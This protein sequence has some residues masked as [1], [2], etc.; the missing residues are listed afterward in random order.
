MKKSILSKIF[1]LFIMGLFFAN[2]LRAQQ[3]FPIVA[4]FTQLPP[5]PVYLADFSNPNQQNLSVQIQIRDQKLASRPIRLKLYIEGQ[6]FL[7]ESADLVQGEPAIQLNLG[8]I[9]DIPKAQLANYFKQ[10]NLKVTPDLY[11]KPFSEGRFRFGI[12]VIDFVTNRPLSGIQWGDPVFIVQNDPPVWVI[13]TDNS[14]QTPLNSQNINF[15]WA[16][17]HR[18]AS[19][20][21][22]EFTITELL[23]GENFSGNIQ[24]LFLSQ[25][26][27]K[28]YRTS[29]TT[30]N[31]NTTF[32]GL[33]PGRTYAYRVQAIAKRG[34]EDVGVFRNNGF[35]EIRHFKYGEGLKPPTN[36]KLAWN[37]DAKS[38]TF[39]WK[40]E[41]NHKSYEIEYREKGTTGEWKKLNVTPKNGLLNTEKI[42]SIQ[43][44]KTYDFKL[45][46][47]GDQNQRAA[48]PLLSI[49][50]ISEEEYLKKTDP[51]VQIEGKVEW[52]F[53][54][55]AAEYEDSRFNEP[56]ITKSVNAK[57]ERSSFQIA[58]KKEYATDKKFDLK[59]AIVSLYSSDK[60][61]ITFENLK[62][63]E[64]SLK[65]IETVNSD[66]SGKYSFKSKKLKSLKDLKNLYVLVKYKDASFQQE[67]RKIT[68]DEKSTTT[69]QKVE[70]IL[71][72]ANTFRFYP[73]ILQKVNPPV[74]NNRWGGWGF[75]SRQPTPSATPDEN[76]AIEALRLYRLQSVVDNNPYL[77]NEGNTILMGDSRMK[78]EYNG[79]NYIETA[80]FRDRDTHNNFK[81]G[82][83]F[84]NKQYNDKFVLEVKARGRKA[85]IFPINSIEDF[86]EL[87]ELNVTEYIHFIMPKQTV[88]GYVLA[89]DKAN[90]LANATVQAFGQSFKT[91]DKGYYEIEV[92]LAAKTSNDPEVRKVSVTDPLDALN[93]ITEEVN[94]SNGDV[95]KDFVF[96]GKAFTITGRVIDVGETPIQG[97]K[98]EYAGQVQT[99]TSEGIFMFV[100]AGDAPKGDIEISFDGFTKK[101]IAANSFQKKEIPK[102]DNEIKWL[103]AIS[104]S[105]TAKK[106][107]SF[108]SSSSKAAVFINENRTET[109]KK[110]HTE[111]KKISM[112][113]YE[114]ASI[115]LN[116]VYKIKLIT[117]TSEDKR[118]ALGMRNL[119]DSVNKVN[120]VGYLN[121]LDADVDI[122]TTGY[123]TTTADKKLTVK[124]VNKKDA[125]ELYLEDE[126][127]IQLPSTITKRDTTFTFYVKLNPANYF[128][129][130]VLDS[131][132]FVNGV[133][134]TAKIK[135]VKRGEALRALA[136]AKVTIEDAS[137]TTDA[138]GFFKVLV[139]KGKELSV[140]IEKQD[141]TKIEKTVTARNAEQ[142]NT[143]DTSKKGNRK[144]FYLFGL[145]P[146]S[147]K[148]KTMLGFDI[149]VD[150]IRK[151]SSET[152]IMSGKLN[153]KGGKAADANINLLYKAEGTSVL[154][155]KD[156]VV[157]KPKIADKVNLT[158]AIPVLSFIN[159]VEI[160][161]EMKMFGYAP[162]LI[163]GNPAG[164]PHLRLQKIV[165]GKITDVTGGKIGGSTV[166]F[167]KKEILLVDFGK[168]EL[169]EITAEKEKAFGKFNDKVSDD[170]KKELKKDITAAKETTEAKDAAKVAE[171]TA[172]NDRIK[173]A[174]KAK[175]DAI[176]Q[177]ADT[178]KTGSAQEKKDAATTVASAKKEEKDAK[179]AIP[180]DVP[181]KEPLFLMLSTT[182]LEE[183]ADTK[184][185]KIVFKTAANKAGRNVDKNI[186]KA[187]AKVAAATT[188]AEKKKAE[189]NQ[190]N[191]NFQKTSVVANEDYIIFPI[192]NS[193]VKNVAEV[194][195]SASP[196][197]LNVEKSSA[198]IKKSG[199]TMK[200]VLSFPEILFMKRDK[201]ILV[202]KLE[203]GKD[204]GLKQVIFAN[205][206][207]GSKNIAELSI[208][209]SWM[210]TLDNIQIFNNFKGYG[211]GGKIMND[212]ENYVIVKSLAFVRNNGKTYPNV[213]MDLPESGFKVSKV[214]FKTIGKKSISFK[215]NLIDN[216]YEL[217]GS[218]KV[219][220]DNGDFVKSSTDSSN[221]F[222]KAITDTTIIK[223]RAAT[224]VAEETKKAEE[225][226]KKKAAE[227]AKTEEQKKADKD[228][229]TAGKS[230]TDLTLFPIELHRFTWSTSGK[231]LV[232]AKIGKLTFSG[233]GINV[234]RFVFAKS[235]TKKDDKGN[236]LKDAKGESVSD[237][238][239]KSDIT[240]L[241]KLNEDE[242]AKMNSTANFN[243]KQTA[244]KTDSTTGTKLTGA[245]SEE[246]QK[247][248]AGVS[249]GNLSVKEVADKVAKLDPTNTGWAFGIAGGIVIE[250]APKG[251]SFDSD[252][253]YLIGNFGKGTEFEISEIML[254][255]DI[256]GGRGMVKVKVA[257]SGEK[258]GFEGTGDIET[259]GLKLAGFL[260]LY[261]YTGTNEI[262][263]GLGFQMSTTIPMGNITWTSLGGGIDL[264]FK[265]KKFKISFIGSAINTG[266]SKKIMEYK[267]IT[268]AVLFDGP[269]CSGW[270]VIKGSMELW[271]TEEIFCS[272]SVEIDLCNPRLM[273]KVQ[274]NIEVISGTKAELNALFIAS[275]DGG[276]LGATLRAELMGASI[277]GTFALGLLCDTQ[278]ITM[279]EEIKDYMRLLPKYLIADDNRTFSGIYLGFEMNK[280]FNTGGTMTVFKIPVV[281]YQLEGYAKGKANVGVNFANGNFMVGIDIRL[282]IEGF[283]S[284]LGARLDGKIDFI[285]IAQGGKTTELG[286]NYKAVIGGTVEVMMGAHQNKPCNDFCI[287]CLSCRRIL[288]CSRYSNMFF[289]MC[290][291][292]RFGIQYHQ[293]G[294]QQG[295]RSVKE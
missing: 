61:D 268:V 21:E 138:K 250:N 262:E 266:T 184:E 227:D 290:I 249:S 105:E 99:T 171:E 154:T 27:F 155:F 186:E 213:E 49:A 47:L 291:S 110:N 187:D 239:K 152:F 46:A 216:E 72:L 176:K 54:K 276:F 212:K 217:D 165:G 225:E 158:N 124:V 153:L 140:K 50:G 207:E 22:Y 163:E 282:G 107:K 67:F 224:R 148:F 80:R 198:V 8:Q 118:N 236:A 127:T 195:L 277:N 231:F 128:H 64:T 93:K 79:D 102:V 115:Q 116:T 65:L 243:D 177:A 248:R 91:N 169:E 13:P 193:L 26:H 147:P 219:E 294:Y 89:P 38:L 109:Y 29:L 24:N 162:V 167:T 245:L 59:D 251:I 209:D 68:I 259:A 88:S 278:G 85:V 122:P 78:L 142:F 166:Q 258:V 292:G 285:L 92:P 271:K 156:I 48:A 139:P 161:V 203:I 218:L 129:G 263:F 63:N 135:P 240:N 226:T 120:V 246:E 150:D 34:N 33:I 97:A 183:L 70:P 269:K 151:N 56:L 42:E 253:T 188:D 160:E 204:F 256:P 230:T 86:E 178:K 83:I 18:N 273:A 84:Y 87:K 220:L 241:L 10:Y 12:E 69:V 293:K 173:A 94:L 137:T 71:V 211:I 295:Y 5:Y 261:Q 264:D 43:A 286:W 191:A 111:V 2:T 52:V 159:F 287:T 100:D 267:A 77:K 149:T 106:S 45:A 180:T 101:T 98:V 117:Y 257:T 223:S 172:K 157:S 288:R 189:A 113:V 221:R 141:Y 174:T 168:M 190:K 132:V 23:I 238:I 31:Y 28:E 39:N 255:L 199:I 280:E 11:K 164:E 133:H 9:Y 96:T 103:E 228:K 181:E 55:V 44:N 197:S 1:G 16:A 32:P 247:K 196:V 121:V 194:G 73:K 75:F 57:S 62:Q 35:S 7:F 143:I 272:V 114:N 81:V 90:P 126:T 136:D 175:E 252:V 289:K 134:D 235:G 60:S 222:G 108:A 260:K 20:V 254:K 30:I 284:V 234:R 192:G 281:R 53:S 74:Q 233:I 123:T 82:A 270:P 215:Y 229:A 3:Y 265:L 275:K 210:L 274:C 51:D 244:Y 58:I 200:G 237:G 214:R 66:N 182:Y 130:I 25:P 19:N 37:D 125:K 205:G 144:D 146:A 36:L 104:E 40:G 76:I 131:T 112:A 242:V 202:D 232:A 41:D 279:K 283:V 4:K 95:T 206:T 185:Y 179:N 170:K 14:P 201:P 208:K 145:D 119:K 15:Q 6:G 17:R